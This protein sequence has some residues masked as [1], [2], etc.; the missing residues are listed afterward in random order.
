[1]EA[2]DYFVGHYMTLCVDSHHILRGVHI[3]GVRHG[4]GYDY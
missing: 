4:S 3:G 2:M 1:M